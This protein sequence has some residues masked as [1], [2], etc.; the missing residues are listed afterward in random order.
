M[1]RAFP[2][3]PC[4][5][6][7]IIVI[8]YIFVQSFHKGFGRVKL[9][10]VKEL[11]F[12]Y[13]EKILH[14]GVVQTIPFARHALED[15]PLFEAFAIAVMLVLPALVGMEHEAVQ[16]IE[17]GEGLLQ[18]VI[19][20]LEVGAPR[21]VVRDDLAVIHVQYRGQEQLG[22]PDAYLCHVGCPLAIR[23]GRREVARD[24]VGSHGS[25]LSLVGPVTD[26]ADLAAQS[27]FPHQTEHRL[28]V[29]HQTPVA[30]LGGDAP[31]SVAAFVLVEDCLYRR[32]LRLTAV[33]I[34]RTLQMVIKHGAC[35]L[36][37]I[38]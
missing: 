12:H 19:H 31:I 11:G 2:I 15:M 30:H 29:D 35:H 5:D 3:Q 18:H 34:P 32:F 1:H 6:S 16:G 17:L 7:F 14:H 4:F 10:G 37:Q 13:S 9:L 33:P 22:R 28:V 25:D 36:F 21:Y 26:A 20:L 24:Q 8:L 23:G 38:Q 27:H